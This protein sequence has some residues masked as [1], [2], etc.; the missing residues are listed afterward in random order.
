[1]NEAAQLHWSSRAL[2]RQI[3]TLYYERFLVSCEKEP[4]K[5]AAA[6]MIRL[7]RNTP[8]AIV[9]DPVV[10]E[11]LGIPDSG[12]LQESTMEQALIDKLQGFLMELGKGFALVERQQRISTESDDCYVDL[13]FYNYFLKCFVLF[14]LKT[15]TL[16]HQALGQ[17]DRYVRIYDDL[18]RGPE[19]NPTVGVILC[20][21]KTNPAVRY[22]VLNE[23][24]QLFA[25]TYS[26][27]LPTEEQ[28]RDELV[29]NFLTI[30]DSCRTQNLV[31]LKDPVR[32]S[33]RGSV[34]AI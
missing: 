25:N 23:H 4:V 3:S 17:M 15:G 14:D 13:V 18:R 21:D 32:R 29:R 31:K 16:T 12:R 20:A 11:F 6:D 2:D 1:M 30:E 22:S 5:A 24:K 8:R 28:L 7:V 9:R 26:L 34:C 10:L 27:V 19:D 33:Q